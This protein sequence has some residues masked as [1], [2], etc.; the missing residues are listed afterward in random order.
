MSAAA[1]VLVLVLLG[2]CSRITIVDGASGSLPP[3]ASSDECDHLRFLQIESLK[4]SNLGG[5]GPDKDQ[6]EGLVYAAK[7][8]QAGLCA[9]D[10]V[11][12]HVHAMSGWEFMYSEREGTELSRDAESGPRSGGSALGRVN[13]K[14]GTSATLQIHGH[15]PATNE[16]VL[17]P[18]VALTF[19]DLDAGEDGR[20]GVEYVKVERYKAYLLTNETEVQVSQDSTTFSASREGDSEDDP[21]D[22]LQLTVP[23]KNRM[24]SFEFEDQREITVQLGA[25]P[26]SAPRA[27]AFELGPALRC[28]S[29]LLEDGTVMPANSTDPPVKIIRAGE[30]TQPAALAVLAL[31][32][33]A[34][35]CLVENEFVST[36]KKP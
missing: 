11:E 27:F 36:A 17:L 34:S 25:S 3:L 7:A 21:E 4:S 13:V 24:V 35:P 9:L 5:Q 22:S 15:D 30:H 14:P 31:A 20:S 16:E 19:F 1:L 28:A 32:L 23:Q 2:L 26:G 33:L 10:D 29:T 18:K 8:C 6:P 12:V